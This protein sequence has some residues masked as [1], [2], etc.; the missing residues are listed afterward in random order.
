MSET[1]ANAGVPL[2]NLGGREQMKVVDWT[3]L[4]LLQEIYLALRGTREAIEART[5]RGDEK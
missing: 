1:V 4:R 5:A 3:N 2:D